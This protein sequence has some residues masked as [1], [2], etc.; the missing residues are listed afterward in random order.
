MPDGT[1]LAAK[2]VDDKLDDLLLDQPDKSVP[3]PE[4][5]FFG[6]AR[7]PIKGTGGQLVQL[8][9]GHL[10]L[11]RHAP[12]ISEGERIR[13]QVGGYPREGKP[14]PLRKQT[15]LRGKFVIATEGKPGL[16]VS[17]AVR[18]RKIRLELKTQVDGFLNSNFWP[19]DVGIIIRTSSQHC[20]E[21]V[22]EELSR[23]SKLLEV[24][25]INALGVK[26]MCVLK[27]PSIH[28][29]ARRDWVV[30]KDWDVE[31]IDESE[32]QD[33]YDELV[34]LIQHSIE[35]TKKLSSGATVVFEQTAAMV[36]ID[37]NTGSLV[38][39][40]AIQ[41]VS[42]EVAQTLC[43]DLRIRGL[44]GK[45]VVDFPAMNKQNRKAI[46]QIIRSSLK[47]DE[48][49][50]SIHGWTRMGNFEMERKRDR[51]LAMGKFHE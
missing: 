19:D 8:P 18:D 7:R 39:G 35:M 28:E 20:P 10:G 16:N 36:T 29:R 34:D 32:C 33:D 27:G 25:Q 9:S 1:E 17:R 4:S 46:E 45:V 37:V 47:D 30:S 48:V 2:V 38:Q 44:A 22:K 40:N 43:R 41:E 5:I 23:W 26:P 15:V 14:V 6:H 24:M 42:R 21:G 50:T 3:K 49:P 13:V 11:L 12:E 31:E 51:V